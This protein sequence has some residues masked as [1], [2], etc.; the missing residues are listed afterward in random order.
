MLRQSRI[1]RAVWIG[2]W[3]VVALEAPIRADLI[4]PVAGVQSLVDFNTFAGT[5]FSP[6]PQPGQLDSTAWRVSGFSDGTLGYGDTGV[7]GDFARGKSSGGVTSGG[8]YAFEVSPGDWALGV[9]ATASE[10]N[11]GFLELRVQN[12]TG[13]LSDGWTVQYDLYCRNDQG[14][15]SAWD[16]SYSLDGASFV[17]M[18][19]LNYISP[20]A[21]DS[22]AFVASSFSTTLPVSVAD[23]G[24]LFLRWSSVDFGGSGSRDE[25]AL[26]NVG[27]TALPAAGPAAVPEPG[28]LVLTGVAS[29]LAL[30]YR[31]AAAGA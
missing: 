12:A 10:F 8:V 16:F 6:N 23:G 29:A 18:P 4:V 17:G 5:G 15:S 19:E 25:F 3:V 26:D 28:T 1:V 30:A 7:T 11:P 31:L 2:V 21:A 13:G 27:I 9:Q 14:R 22:T 24:Q 20:A